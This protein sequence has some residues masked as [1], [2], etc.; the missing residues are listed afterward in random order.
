MS[1]LKL[2]PVLDA[3]L[4][5]DVVDAYHFAAA[6]DNILITCPYPDHLDDRPS[7]S[8]NLLNG[9]WKCHGCDRTGNYNK[10]IQLLEEERIGREID[11][12]ELELAKAAIELGV[13]PDE[14]AEQSDELVIRTAKAVTQRV[15]KRDQ[16]ALFLAQE[17]FYTLPQADWDVIQYHY[18]Q[19]R[20]FTSIS[21]KHFD[22]RLNHASSFSIVI[23]VY[24][25]D[26]FYG[27]VARKAYTVDKH[28]TKYWNN[29][30]LN[31][32]DLVFGNL[33]IGPVLIVEGPLDMIKA[34]QY[35]FHNVCCL[36]GWHCSDAQATH[37]RK[38]ATEIICGLDGD[39]RGQQG[40]CRL[41]EI[42][43]DLPLRKFYFPV[44]VK[45]VD[46]MDQQTFSLNMYMPTVFDTEKEEQNG[47]DGRHLDG[48]RSKVS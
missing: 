22:I 23:P 27:Y 11:G 45:D 12:W 6:T 33:E 18:L 42:F 34:W 36:F 39:V 21:L 48:C 20:N 28:E 40:F 3:L 8:V 29:P 24:Q 43:S 2:C 5:Y 31:K 25:Q 47:S 35:G 13:D 9:L 26:T 41:Q 38:F 46:E 32:S 44:G 15:S 16:R 19:R 1:I 7:C 10:L 14:T 37:I 17:F 30:G 4:Y